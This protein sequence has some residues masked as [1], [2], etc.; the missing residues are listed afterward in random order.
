MAIDLI[1]K[2]IA[3][4]QGVGRHPLHSGSGLGAIWRFGVAQ[5][6]ARLVPGDVCVVFPNQTRLLIPPRM[7]GAAHFIMPGL[8]EFEPMSFVAHFL[9][10]GDLFVD[11]GANLGAYTLLA[12]G[13]AGARTLA[14]EPGRL[15]FSYL[16]RN[17][18]L[19]N[20]DAITTSLN[21]ALGS[22][23]GKLHLTDGLGTEN[24]LCS[25]GPSP[26]R[27]EV[28]VSTLDR[29]LSLLDP[30]LIKIDVEGYEPEV[31]SG[32]VQTLKTPSLRG[33]IIERAE[34]AVRYGQNEAALHQHLQALGFIPCAYAPF[35]RSLSRLPPEAQGNIIYLKN[36]EE[37]QKRLQLAAPF[38]FGS[39]RI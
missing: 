7:K 1:R 6:A 21:V 25:D 10:S 13:V 38:Q 29:V 28:E 18:W 27:V 19:N 14:V 36:I 17:I 24:H 31:I 39:F 34:N 20:L 26:G 32:A 16:V 8:C 23:P 22:R 5:L 12:S 4:A 33:L 9:R 35:N 30:A 2:L 15:A 3:T 37:A 11:V